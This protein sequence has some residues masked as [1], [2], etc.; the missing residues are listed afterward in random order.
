MRN[1]KFRNTRQVF[2]P[3]NSSPIKFPADRN[4]TSDLLN[5][6]IISTLTP[7]RLSCEFL[8][9]KLCCLVITILNPSMGF[10][11]SIV[12]ILTILLRSWTQSDPYILLHRKLG[13]YFL[14]SN[15]HLEQNLFNLKK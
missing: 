12:I 10:R 13:R 6:R 14:A 2:H 8:S 7:Y 4:V 15:P 5:F 1:F 3:L 9:Q 11:G